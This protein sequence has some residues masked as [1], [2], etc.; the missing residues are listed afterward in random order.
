MPDAAKREA[1]PMPHPYIKNLF[2]GYPNASQRLTFIS[3]PA[4]R[5]SSPTI[6]HHRPVHIPECSLLAVK[7]LPLYL[8][9]LLVNSVNVTGIFKRNSVNDSNFK[10]KKCPIAFSS[11]S[12]SKGMQTQNSS[13]SKELT[14][15]VLQ[16]A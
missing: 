1:G 15:L 10:C 6:T 16:L 7:D 3:G 9:S 11:L 8:V 14:L 5:Q 2:P 4:H 12:P 13:S